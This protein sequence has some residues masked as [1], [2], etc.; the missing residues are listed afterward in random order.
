MNKINW[1]TPWLMAAAFGVAVA[2]CGT[3]DSGSSSPATGTQEKTLSVA[4]K[5]VAANSQND[6]GLH[7]VA[8]KFLN[9]DSEVVSFYE[10]LAG[11]IMFFVAGSPLG[12]HSVLNRDLIEGKTVPEL[13]NLVAPGQAAPQPLAQAIANMRNAAPVTQGPFAETA[14][15]TSAQSPAVQLTP[16]MLLSGGY[17][18]NGGFQHDWGTFGSGAQDRNPGGSGENFLTGF[19]Q[20]AYNGVTNEA[21]YAACET[22]VPNNGSGTLTVHFP[23]GQVPTFNLGPDVFGAAWYFAGA[24]CGFDVQCGQC[25][26][27]PFCSIG[28]TRCT[29]VGFNISGSFSPAGSDI[30]EWIDFAS[31]KGPYCPCPGASC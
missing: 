14:Q 30:Y 2:G 6:A 16:E 1:G 7:L 28:G 4:D 12:G 22:G 13:W 10:P 23:N 25:N 5:W 8:R 3:S 18:L 21:G 27:F 17:C 24:N 11:H 15:P 19:H 29:P 26:P 31:F 9:N 20:Q